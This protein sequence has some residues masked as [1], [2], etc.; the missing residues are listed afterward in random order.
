VQIWF[1][2]PEF[3]T[4]D[5]QVPGAYTLCVLPINGN[6]SDPQFEQRLQDHMEALLVYC[7]PAQI[8]A[9]PDKQTITAT[10]PPMAPLPD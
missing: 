6:L 2:G 9:S 8:K 3:P 5:K 7:Q 1:G 10:V 4:Y